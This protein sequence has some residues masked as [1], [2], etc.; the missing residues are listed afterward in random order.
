MEKSVQGMLNQGFV[1]YKGIHFPRQVRVTLIDNGK[2]E[3]AKK[4]SVNLLYEITEERLKCISISV[5]SNADNKSISSAFLQSL[6]VES[7]GREALTTLALEVKPN[8]DDQ[9][10][11][12]ELS[13]GRRA[14]KDLADGVNRLSLRELMFIGFHYSN[15]INAK[16]PTKAVETNMGY[17]SRHTALRRIAL[18]RTKNWILPRGATREEIDSHFDEIRKRLED[19]SGAAS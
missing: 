6:D 13:K 7:L 11:P 12:A 4:P 5:N 8:T 9:L 2:T 17:G 3:G 1:R 15:P 10:E 16:S 14:S 18:A 19:G